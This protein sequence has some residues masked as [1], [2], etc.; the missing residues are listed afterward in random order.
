MENAFGKYVFKN[1]IVHRLEREGK[2]QISNQKRLLPINY[3]FWVVTNDMSNR[4]LTCY[5]TQVFYKNGM[6]G[7]LYYILR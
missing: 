2:C 7:W 1:V 6:P 5:I 3:V 4:D